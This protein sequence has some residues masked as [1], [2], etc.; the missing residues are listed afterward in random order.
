MMNGLKKHIKS[1]G[2]EQLI[3]KLA[4]MQMQ[5]LSMKRKIQRDISDNISGAITSSGKVIPPPPEPLPSRLLREGEEPPKR[6]SY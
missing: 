2:T 1:H 5:V 4:S 3:E 6:R